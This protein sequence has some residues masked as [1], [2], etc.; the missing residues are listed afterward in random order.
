MRDCEVPH[1]KNRFARLRES[2]FLC[3]GT[4]EILRLRGNR[5]TLPERRERRRRPHGNIRGGRRERGE[6]INNTSEERKYRARS[7]LLKILREYRQ[8]PQ[9]RT[10]KIF[11]LRA[12]KSAYLRGFCRCLRKAGF[13]GFGLRNYAGQGTRKFGAEVSELSP[14]SRFVPSRKFSFMPI[15]RRGI[16]IAFRPPCRPRRAVGILKKS[17][18]FFTAVRRAYTATAISVENTGK[19]RWN[20]ETSSC[21]SSVSSESSQFSSA[22]ISF[23]AHSKYSS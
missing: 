2:V 21:G 3:R 16:S 22:C 12:A 7:E 8:P 20:C 23:F 15:V 9:S 19:M 11:S 6:L 1:K 13:C 17:V 4:G 14:D 10:R 18:N 5:R